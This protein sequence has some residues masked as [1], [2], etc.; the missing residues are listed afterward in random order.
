MQQLYP[1]GQPLTGRDF[2]GCA[3]TGTYRGMTRAVDPDGP[4]L[5][6]SV[7]FVVVKAYADGKLYLCRPHEVSVYTFAPEN[8]DAPPSTR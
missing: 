4:L 7:P 8:E 3:V 2:E 6:A 5:A 1:H